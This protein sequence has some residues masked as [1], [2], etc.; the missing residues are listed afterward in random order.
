MSLREQQEPEMTRSE[1]VPEDAEA[2]PGCAAGRAA[3][4]GA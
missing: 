4:R 2:V 1:H 3:A